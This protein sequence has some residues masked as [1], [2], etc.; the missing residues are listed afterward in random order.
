MV[1]RG[2]QP[3]RARGMSPSGKVIPSSAIITALNASSSIGATETIDAQQAAYARWRDANG[4]KAPGVE[5]AYFG[6]ADDS[7]MRYRGVRATTKVNEGD[8]LVELPREACLVLMDDAELP[9]PEFCTGELWAR[10][11]EKNRWAVKVALNLLHEVHLGEAGKFHT[12]IQQLPR[13]FDLLSAWSD[14]ELKMLQYDAVV[15]AAVGQRK[16]DDD[17]WDLV[18][19]YSPSTP[20]TKDRLVWALNMVRSR[21]FSGRLSDNAATKAALLPRALAAGT[22]VITFLTSPTQEGRWVAVFAMLALVIFDAQPEPGEEGGAK[23]AYVLMPLIDAFNHRNMPK[24]EFEFSSSAFRLRSPASYGK[25]EEVL[26]SYGVLGNDELAVRYGFADGEN[27]SDVY[28]YEGLLT[29]L[30]ANHDPL[31]KSLGAAPDR[32]KAGLRAARLES[33]VSMGV[34]KADGSADDNLMWGLRVLMATPEQWEAAGGTPEGLKLGGGAPEKAASVALAA[35][36]KARLAAMG[37]TLEEDA[38]ALES[39]SLVG[40]ERT[41]VQYRLRKKQ[42][43]AAAV[44]KYDV[45]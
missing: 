25:G 30:Q 4:V 22:L 18:Q 38:A 17:A 23:L 27:S 42:I 3:R 15:R 5:V 32:V 19:R 2:K 26:I 36:C 10:L 20:V 40:R 21:V 34:I 9:F 41:A 7:V 13:D 31:K 8:V 33:Y 11:T 39:G 16:E 12:Y 45:A 29:W 6:E 24:T 35:A 28:A 14:E 43:L 44:A 37:T 1:V